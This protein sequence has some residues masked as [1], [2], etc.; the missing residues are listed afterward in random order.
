[1]NLLRSQHAYN[2][3]KRGKSWNSYIIAKMLEIPF[4]VVADS[5]ALWRKLM[6]LTKLLSMS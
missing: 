2:G 6:M 1:M 3:Q 5:G 4:Y